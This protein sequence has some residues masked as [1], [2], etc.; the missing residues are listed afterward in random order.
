MNIKKYIIGASAVAT[1]LSST[2]LL[3]S[4]Q[5]EEQKS[6]MSDSHP[7]PMIVNI[8][9]AGQTLLRGTVKTIGTN[10]LTVTSWGGDWIIN[11]SSDTKV[12]PVS[13]LTK[14]KVGDFVGVKGNVN[15]SAAWTI[16]ANLVRDWMIKEEG[17]SMEKEIKEL[18]KAEI[19]KNWQGTASNV[20]ASAKTLTLSI[21][22]VAY[23]VNIVDTAK[24]VS[25]NYAAIDFASIKD[26]DTVRVWGLLSDTTITAYV[27]R[28]VSIIE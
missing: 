22:N 2:L 11:V 27:V 9:P 4:V 23:N 21:E 26:G 14:F 28:D 3:V 16:D 12:R 25:K 8:G 15:Q 20:N 24:V 1:I 18:M 17:Q 19:P 6:M 7:Q 5:A 13:D 10:S